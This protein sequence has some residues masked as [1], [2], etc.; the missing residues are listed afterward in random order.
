M[1]KSVE[2]ILTKDLVRELGLDKASV[3]T[4]DMLKGYT[5]IGDYAF[6][7][8]TKLTSI[9]IPDSVTDIGYEA[10]QS[11]TN[12]TSVTIPD[13]VTSI[14]GCVSIIVIV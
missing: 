5:S 1:N 9:E 6:E 10:F 7:D 13:S 4:A 11:C 8:C 2:K 3:I 12:L 14:G